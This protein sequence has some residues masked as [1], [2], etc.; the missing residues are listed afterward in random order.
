M[1]PLTPSGIENVAALL[2]LCDAQQASIERLQLALSEYEQGE[3]DRRMLKRMLAHELRTPL[4]AIIGTLHTLRIPGLPEDKVDELWERA[5]RQSQQL[6]DMIDDVLHLSEPADPT[7]R[8]APQEWVALEALVEDVQRAVAGELVPTRLVISVPSGL[9]IRTIPGRVRQILVNLLV[10]AGR[11][12]PAGSPVHLSAER[13]PEAF[14]FEV[15]DRGPG[16]PPETVEALF[17]PFRRGS[18]ATASDA[19]VGL[20]LYLVRNLCRSL[21]GTVELLPHSIGGTVARVTLPQKRIEDAS[22]SANGRH[23][24]RVLPTPHA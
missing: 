22:P 7:V 17:E 19:G 8:R 5:L 24:L 20:G 11:Y 3:A 9:S 10:N 1:E 16:I 21:G 18:G 12:S 2:E 6:S 14:Q 4:A 23:H 15:I 13:L